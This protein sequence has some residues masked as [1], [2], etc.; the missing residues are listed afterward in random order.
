MI[1]LFRARPLRLGLLASSV[2][3][4]LAVVYWYGTSRSQVEMPDDRRAYLAWLSSIH[5]NAGEAVQE[6]IDLLGEYPTFHPLYLRLADVCR[7]EEAYEACQTA[8]KKQQVADAQ[9][10]LYRKA[11]L[12]LLTEEPDT[13]LWATVARSPALNPTLARYVVDELAASASETALA[14]VQARWQKQLAADS[15]AV[16]AAFGLGYAIGQRDMDAAERLLLHARNLA[17]DDP[18]IHRELGRIYFYTGQTE[19]FEGTLRAGIEAASARHDLEQALILRGNLGLGLMKE[20]GGVEKAQVLFEEALRESRQLADGETEGYNLYRLAG[21]RMKQH[22]YDEALALL[23]SADVRYQKHTPQKRADV[24]ILRGTALT[25]LFRFGEAR[26]LLE[27]VVA[28]S[29]A[30]RNIGAEIQASLALAQLYFR[31]GSYGAARAMGLEVLDDGQRYRL[32][33]IEVAARIVLGDVERRLGNMEQAEAHYEQGLERVPEGSP[34]QTELYMRLGRTALDMQ[35]ASAAEVYYSELVTQVEEREGTGARARIQE[36]LG[37]AYSLFGNYEQA[38]LYFDEAIT[39][40]REAGATQQLISVLLK[41]AWTLIDQADYDAADAV[42]EEATKLTRSQDALPLYASRVEAAWGGLRLNQAQYDL[43][44]RH[45]ERAEEIEAQYGRPL[46]QWHVLH[47]IALAHW[48]LG[49]AQA[50]ERYFLSAIETVEAMRDNLDVREHRAAFVQDKVG[51][52]KNFSAF[53]EEQGRSAE[54]FHYAERSRSRSLADLLVTTLGTAAGPRS[55]DG[56]K[57]EENQVLEIAQNRRVLRGAIDDPEEDVEIPKETA[58][59]VRASMLRQE[60]SRVDSVYQERVQRLPDSSAIK[61][62][63][64]AEPLEA[65]ETQAVLKEGEAMIVYDLRSEQDGALDNLSALAT[66][67]AYVI[68]PETITAQTLTVEEESLAEMIRLFR[69]QIQSVASGGEPGSAWETASRKLYRDLVAPV[70]AKLPA[71]TDHLHLVPEGV[72]H[73]L[74]FAALQDEKGRFLVEDF[75]LSVTPSASIL[76]ICRRRNPR[77]LWRT[78]L[79]VADP[80]GEL[81][82]SRDEALAIASIDPSVR[83]HALI[84]EQATQAEFEEDAKWADIIHIAT[85]GRFVSQAPWSSY[86][87]LH[88]DV[89]S[90]DEIGHLKLDAYLVTLS[91]CETALSGGF[92]SDV[93]AGDEWVGLNQAFLAA[94]TP[95]VMASLWPI[96]DKVS[97]SFMIS[98]YEKLLDAHGK[99]KALSQAQR[100]ALINPETSHP[101]YWAAFTVIGDPL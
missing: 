56:L 52:Y 61:P 3:A 31:M 45:L 40:Y 55:G 8:L 97:S 37:W 41:K 13:V 78:I 64:L 54:A 28:A 26:Q 57:S 18:Q 4:F 60:Y 42:L 63:L 67:V 21:V 98:F 79:A 66:S 58:D 72:L 76:E 5:Q 96:D 10:E 89:L 44:L 20:V 43:A 12:G 15:S 82:G 29:A 95:T 34:R 68:T 77:G 46:V 17:P 73:Y 38:G 65:A 84:G 35:D 27:D 93:P 36:G 48:G 32:E 70:L 6:G 59:P 83:G 90:A 47:A 71:S 24:Q 23:D 9:T 30:Q 92:T 75:S 74:P 69:G 39:E 7:A 16:G 99:S 80:E 22:R 94:G 81:P 88:G 62:L 51:V 2:L 50:A 85:H 49:D 53:L 1:H 86:L 14:D 11:A 87:E 91:A 25:A 100:E 19:A 101:F 33:D